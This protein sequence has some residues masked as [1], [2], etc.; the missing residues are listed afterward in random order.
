[1]KFSRNS[2]LLT[3]G[4]FAIAVAIVFYAW[5]PSFKAD[6]DRER[7]VAGCVNR[8]LQSPLQQYSGL[9]LGREE[10]RRNC[11]RDYCADFECK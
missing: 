3:A 5:W 6:R 7:F 11:I 2:L 8:E 4:L 9:R 1:M 10:I